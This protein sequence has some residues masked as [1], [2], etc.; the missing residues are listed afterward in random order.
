MPVTKST[1]SEIDNYDNTETFEET[2]NREDE[3][4]RVVR[5]SVKLYDTMIFDVSWRD[6]LVILNHGGHKT[7]TAK[8]RMNEAL[9]AVGIDYKVRQIGGEWLL[10]DTIDDKKV[11]SFNGEE[12]LA[13]WL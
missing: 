7:K 4:T 10:I 2:Y 9:D 5:T 8:R 13:F 6:G 12:R 1:L 11:Q 3:D